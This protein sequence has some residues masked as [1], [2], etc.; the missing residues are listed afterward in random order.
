[1]KMDEGVDTGDI[2][3][4][5]RVE[6]DPTDTGGSL[7]QK[8]SILGGDLLVEVLPGYLDGRLKPQP[9]GSSPTPYAPMLKKAD[10]ELDFNQPADYISRQVRAY[11]PWPGTYTTYQGKLLKV[12]R[13]FA[14]GNKTVRIGKRTIKD[15]KPAFGTKQG[16]FVVEEIQPAGKKPMTGE[17]FLLGTRDWKE[18]D[19]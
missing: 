8:L 9:Q 15:G 4:Q 19:I 12:L 10:G 18:V 16:F 1:M 7:F 6:I 13:G 3:S 14:S 2:I 11:H 5:R 17:A